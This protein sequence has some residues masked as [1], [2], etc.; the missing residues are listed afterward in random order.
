MRYFVALISASTLCLTACTSLPPMRSTDSYSKM[1]CDDLSS[2]INSV[3]AN[4]TNS[5]DNAGIGFMDVLAGVATGMA[6][7][8][9]RPDLVQQQSQMHES[10]AQ[11]HAIGKAD[12]DA[13]MNRLVLIDKIRS[14]KKCS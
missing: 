12:S 1:S 8:A 14:I 7:G 10:I 6:A 3:Q 5:D 2:E 11:G 9:G 13:Y 4:K